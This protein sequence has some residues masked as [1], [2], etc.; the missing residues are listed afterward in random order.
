MEFTTSNI[1]TNDNNVRS[2]STTPADSGP[3]PGFIPFEWSFD[4]HSSGYSSTL[5]QQYISVEMTPTQT[6]TNTSYTIPFEFQ[7]ANEKEREDKNMRSSW[8]VF[9][10]P[11]KK[12]GNP[13]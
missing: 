10:P 8:T 6:S 2:S 11:T 9:A 3:D 12:D 5:R 13:S 1:T 4:N 7:A